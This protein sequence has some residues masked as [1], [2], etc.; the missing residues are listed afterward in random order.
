MN[1]L[2]AIGGPLNP[3]DLAM[4]AAKAQSMAPSVVDAPVPSG[5]LRSVQSPV[6]PPT[7]LTGTSAVGSPFANLLHDAVQEVSGKQAAATD[8]VNGLLSGQNVS[9]HQAMIAME[10]ANVSFQ[11]MIEVRNKMLEGYQEI[12]RM[13]I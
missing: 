13:Q 4:Y 5:G 1:P 12:M 7:S 2:T 3:R 6:D 11:L 8:A 9:L 10:E